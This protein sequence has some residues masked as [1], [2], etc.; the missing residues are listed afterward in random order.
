MSISDDSPFR[1]P[2]DAEI[3]AA[4]E[5]LALTFH[6][7]YR[8]FLKSGGDV[9]DAI[10]EPAVV[11]PGAARLDLIEIASTAWNLMGVPRHL[12]PF[13][14][15]NGDYY[16]IAPSGEV[17]YWSHNGATDEKWPS[18]AAWKQQVCIERR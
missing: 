10:I 8:A 7:D 15:D 6:P 14:E 16:C 18:I 3:A 11:L 2:T 4:E 17:L 9:A 13:V 5:R 12:L 1:P